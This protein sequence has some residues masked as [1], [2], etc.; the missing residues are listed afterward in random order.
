M[1]ELVRLWKRPSRDG[2]RFTY[3]LIYKDEQGKK[4]F[5]S[6]GHADGRKAERQRAQKERELRMGIVEPGSMKL[7]R[8]LEDYHLNTCGQV[9]PSTLS[10]S[11]RDLREFTSLVGDIDLDTV[12][13]KHGEKFTQHCL[14]QG[15]KP[16]TVN[17]KL[18]HL[19]S[20]F[21]LARKR[22]QLDCNPMHGFK[23]LKVTSKPVKTFSDI[24]VQKL[25]DSAPDLLWQARI[26][27][28][29]CAGLRVGEIFNLTWND[30]GLENAT[31]MVLPKENSRSTWAW[32]AKD[33][34][35]RELPL[36]V[37]AVSVLTEIRKRCSNSQPYPL[38]KEKT[39]LRM[40]RKLGLPANE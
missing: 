15:N 30:I 7:S 26:L 20:I 23:R 8:F 12:K 24:E 9:T 36:S 13:F 31:V 17:K 21:E 35:I 3:V 22:G 25:V 1:K 32:H 11:E 2:K 37:E 5:E 28:A 18:R 40:L 39:Y 33:Y 16:A 4:R 14:A 27:V 10:E 38:I 6:L 34:E 29:R 19:H